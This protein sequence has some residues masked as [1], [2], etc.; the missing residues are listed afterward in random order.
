MTLDSQDSQLASSE[1][2]RVLVSL[3]STR[4]SRVDVPL[5]ETGT[6][7]QN[8]RNFNENFTCGRT[9]NYLSLVIF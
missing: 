2:K 9:K 8:G 4:Y 1:S 7:I 6:V 5:L 3:A